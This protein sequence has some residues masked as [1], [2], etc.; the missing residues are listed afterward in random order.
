MDKDLV[1]LRY[2]LCFAT[3]INIVVLVHE[4]RKSNIVERRGSTV[5]MVIA[6]VKKIPFLEFCYRSA[7][8]TKPA[9]KKNTKNQ[10]LVI[11]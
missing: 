5:F 8:Q 4:L 2:S 7:N 10:A 11:S 3:S 1:M 6:M 9:I